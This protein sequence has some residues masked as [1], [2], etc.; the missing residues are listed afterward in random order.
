MWIRIPT[1][2]QQPHE[3]HFI[4]FYFIFFPF[5]RQEMVY[6]RCPTKRGCTKSIQKATTV[7]TT[8]NLLNTNMG[9]NQWNP[10]KTE[11]RGKDFLDHRESTKQK[12]KK[13]PLKINKT[14]LTNWESTQER[15]NIESKRC[16]LTVAKLQWINLINK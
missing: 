15:L 4:L 9:L 16:C 7:G 5:D 14:S 10:T 13:T 11:P 12:K 3:Q 2:L 8:H 1:I 6:K